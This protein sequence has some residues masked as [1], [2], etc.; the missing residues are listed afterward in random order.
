MKDRSHEEVMAEY[1]RAHPAYAAELLAE[2][3]SDGDP[4]ELKT[5]FHHMV[6]TFGREGTW[7]HSLTRAERDFLSKG[8]RTPDA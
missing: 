6:K 1:F 4:T 5:V 2:V 3:R 8:P 7:W